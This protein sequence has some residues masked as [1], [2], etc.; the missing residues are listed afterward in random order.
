MLIFQRVS[1]VEFLHKGSDSFGQAPIA[2]TP[3][4]HVKPIFINF[5]V[6]GA[7]LGLKKMNRSIHFGESPSCPILLPVPIACHA[8]VHFHRSGVPVPAWSGFSYSTKAQF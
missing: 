4:H 1:A 2:A 6:L 7:R 5:C 8:G 3:M